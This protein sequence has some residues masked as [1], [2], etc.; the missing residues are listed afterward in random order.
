MAVRRG[1]QLLLAVLLAA[2]GAAPAAAAPE[3][4][5]EEPAPAARPSIEWM[6]YVPA[7]FRR[8]QHDN[9]LILLVLDMPWGGRSERAEEELW[10]DPGLVGLIEE[11]FVP[12]RERADLRPDLARRHPAPG[13]PA[14]SLLLPDGTPLAFAPENGGSATPLAL[15]SLDPDRLAAALRQAD[16]YYREQGAAAVRVSREHLA[17]VVEEE[18]PEPGKADPSA[19][20]AAAGQLEGL[21]DVQRRYFG[22]APRFPRLD[23]VELLLLL[24]RDDPE[25]WRSMAVGSL[26]AMLEGLTDPEDGGLRSLARGLDWEDPVPQKLLSINARALELTALA[27]EVDGEKDLAQAAERLAGFLISR[28]G[29]EAGGFATAIAPACPHGRCETVLSGDT[30]L[31]AAALIRAG[32]AFSRKPWI[33]RGL[34]AA[35]FLER[36]RYRSRRGVVRA[37]VDGYAVPPGTIVLEDLAGTAWAFL[38]AHEATGEGSWLR[39]AEDVAGTALNNLSDGKSGVIGDVLISPNAP[40]PLRAAWFPVED[41]A[42][43]ARCLLRIAGKVDAKRGR[44]Y[45]LAAERILSGFAGSERV[46]EPGA[47]AAYGAAA[48]ALG[49]DGRTEPGKPGG[50]G[51]DSGQ[52]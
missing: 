9:A 36:E 25:R 14:M 46:M 48:R 42:R 11:R 34:E 6:E 40:A 21:Y 39:A 4:A 47:R 29:T 37:V 18:R 16:A 51:K 17:S 52:S 13:L 32:R 33:E 26:R 43:L 19:A 27:S 38:A 23:A 5:P 8:A 35:R 20:L 2:R 49:R 10:G 1:L 7:A 15:S 41:N 3:Q 28:L 22:G 45:R 50:G 31:A 30:G 24:S 12:V 44:V